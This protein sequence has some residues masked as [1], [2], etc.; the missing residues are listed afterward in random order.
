MEPHMTEK[1][2]TILIVE[3][4]DEYLQNL[5]AF[6]TWPRYLQAHSAGDAIKIIKSEEV[7]L[8]FLDMRFDR[9][10]H[11]DL[12]GDVNELLDG[13][14]L[15]EHEAWIFIEKNQGLYIYRALRAAGYT[16][17][18][19]LLSYDFSMESARWEEISRS[20]PRVAWI[21]DT[22]TPDGLESRIRAMVA[23]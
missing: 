16:L 23:R 7:N 12:L 10:P 14:S 3:D 15:T 8:V 18:P 6:L 1:Q 20:D 4:G 17:L 21:P 13:F 22:A 11:A 19:V 2:P 5:G 9:T